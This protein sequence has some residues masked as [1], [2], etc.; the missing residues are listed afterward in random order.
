M[1][2]NNI[3]PL[4]P[5]GVIRHRTG[6]PCRN[7]RRPRR[8]GYD[9]SWAQGAIHITEDEWNRY[10]ATLHN[11]NVD[12]PDFDWG[13]FVKDAGTWYVTMVANPI[14]GITYGEKLAAQYTLKY[15]APKTDAA[16]ANE[17]NNNPEL[18]KTVTDLAKGII[19]IPQTGLDAILKSLKGASTT[20]EY[21]PYILIGVLVLGAVFLFMN[22]GTIKR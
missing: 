14:L 17:I 9:P 2:Q 1:N 18:K 5:N 6:R 21:L 8:L 10:M 11:S 3:Y 20:I 22:P 13:G 12:S 16:I 15:L 4:Y 19:S 7:C